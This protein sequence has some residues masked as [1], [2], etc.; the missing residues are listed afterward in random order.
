MT[1]HTFWA[2][3]Q[4][5]AD[6]QENWV[7]PQETVKQ[8]NKQTN[9]VI[10]QCPSLIPTSSQRIPLRTPWN[11]LPWGEKC[12]CSF[13]VH[14][15]S[16][17]TDL[18]SKMTVGNCYDWKD[19]SNLVNFV[20]Y[21]YIPLKSPSPQM[22]TL[23]PKKKIADNDH[24]TQMHADRQSVSFQLFPCATS[25]SDVT[26]LLSTWSPA[27]TTSFHVDHAEFGDKFAHKIMTE[28]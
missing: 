28:Q 7:T 16:D 8:T 14:S 6:A 18:E 21:L 5:S 2:W 3:T 19:E 11:P 13:C 4:E 10:S 12:V 27:H 23:W 17:G 1:S 22:A 25:G 24:V 20:S 15:K 9:S 26:A